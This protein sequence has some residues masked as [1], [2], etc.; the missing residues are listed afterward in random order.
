MLKFESSFCFRYVCEDHEFM[1]ER[2]EGDYLRKHDA[3]NFEAM[4]A[5]TNK[6]N[7]AVEKYHKTLLVRSSFV[8][9]FK[10]LSGLIF[11]DLLFFPVKVRLICQSSRVPL[12]T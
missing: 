7:Q 5:V 12:P 2:M 4:Y 11:I 8:L 6:Y 9:D 10:M 3:T 1:R